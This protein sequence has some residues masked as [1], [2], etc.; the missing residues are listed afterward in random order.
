MWKVWVVSHHLSASDYT[1]MAL[2]E[3]FESKRRMGSK[4]VARTKA[5]VSLAKALYQEEM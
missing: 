5:F 4:P 3:L 1:K 2:V